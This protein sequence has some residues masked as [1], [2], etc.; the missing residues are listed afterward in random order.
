MTEVA[1]SQLLWA[2]NAFIAQADDGGLWGEALEQVC[3]GIG[4]E[5][6]LSRVAL[7]EVQQDE[8]P[9][10][11]VVCRADWA[12]PGLD[13]IGRTRH[14]TIAPDGADDLQRDWAARRIRGEVIQGLTRDLTGYLRAY[15][16]SR[17]IVRFYTVPVMVGG[18]WWGHF[19]IAHDDPDLPWDEA[20][21]SLCHLMAGMVARS[22]ECVRT[23]RE[24]NEVTLRSM[25]GSALDAVISIDEAGMILEFNPAAERIF[26]YERKAVIGRTLG[27]TI[28]P[29]R[30]ATAHQAGLRRYLESTT[31]RILG[32]RVELQGRKADGS[33]FPV[34]LTVTEIRGATRRFFTAYLRDISNFVEAQEALERLAYQDAMTGLPNRAGLVRMVAEVPTAPTGV[35]VVHFRDLD[36]LAASLGREFTEP[37]AAQLAQRLRLALRGDAM[38]ARTGEREFAIV[39]FRGSDALAAGRSVDALF[40]APLESE[41]RR[42]Y[43]RA[44]IGIAREQGQLEHMLRDAEMALHAQGRGH[45]VVFDQSLRADHQERLALE[46]DLRDTILRR[47]RDLYMV[48]QP[49]VCCKTGTVM[50]FEALARWSHPALG[51]VEPSEFVAIAEASGLSE[52]LGELVLERAVAACARWNHDRASL[53]LG[54]RYVSVNL[55]APQVMAPDLV[56][57]IANILQQVNLKGEQVLFELTESTLLSEPEKAVEVMVQLQSLGCKVAIDDFGTGYS[58]F[59]YLQRLPV[60]VLK[61]DRSF[62]REIVDNSRSRRIVGVMVDL[63]HAFG[64]EVVAEGVENDAALNEVVALGSDCVQGYLVGRPMR[65]DDARQWPDGGRAG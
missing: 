50:G 16:E 3:A 61:I 10:L 13:P 47:S 36:V 27:D 49:I 64:I 15:F 55:S 12:R 28:I 32:R 19:C 59:S 39:L 8:H 26:G 6:G 41:G 34:E 62:I 42:F 46:T 35:V 4:R 48:F 38:L 44:R 11:G 33:V 22:A 18:H 29:P 52:Q 1:S 24:L 53:G 2:M 5:F 30:Y 40:Q 37:V 56:A 63:A 21:V 20:A 9:G 54:A 58:S 51:N 17:Q 43:L 25:L 45:A 60:N 57:R 14:R 31:P 7:F 23:E 65:E